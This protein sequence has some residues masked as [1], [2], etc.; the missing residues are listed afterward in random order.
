MMNRWLWG[1]LIAVGT[2]AYLAVG[3][4]VGLDRWARRARDRARA[5]GRVVREVAPRAAA[6][7]PVSM[8]W[9]RRSAIRRGALL[10]VQDARPGLGVALRHLCDVVRPHEVPSL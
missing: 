3:W 5:S 4:T 6:E 8:V 7:C 9:P 10:G 2:M 1:S